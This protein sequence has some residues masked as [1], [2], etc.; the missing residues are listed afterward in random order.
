MLRW[1]GSVIICAY[2][3]CKKEYDMVII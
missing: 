1:V 2:E 3:K